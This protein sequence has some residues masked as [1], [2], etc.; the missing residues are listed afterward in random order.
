MHT[1]LYRSMQTGFSMVELTVVMAVLGL[2]TWA[3]SAAF[4][5]V[6]PT[7]DRERAL[8]VGETLRETV[9]AFALR[10]GH[11]PCPDTDGNG[12]ES[13]A[14]TGNLRCASATGQFGWLPYR[15]LGLDLPADKFRATY[16]VFRNPDDAVPSSDADLAV[17]LER[18]SPA[19]P[20]G[21]V[22]YKNVHDLIAALNNA[23]AQTVP[24]PLV[25]RPHHTG[26]NGVQGAI[27]C[28][29]NVRANPAYWLA[30]PLEDRDGSGS[31]SDGVQA[32]V[33][34]AT[35]VATASLCVQAPGT[36]MT[37]DNDD[38]VIVEPLGVLAGWLQARA[39]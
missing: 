20:V 13:R 27:D 12:W 35:L 14:T 22:G 7:R 10:N 6:G 37:S 9:R 30:M 23:T 2:M 25:T 18:S 16:A 1:V 32:T 38:V 5:N 34:A 28:T 3:V 21:T 8:Q 29:A 26:D 31:R 4:G 15:T 19:D 17:Q 33:T 39:P 24:T 36:A 11:L